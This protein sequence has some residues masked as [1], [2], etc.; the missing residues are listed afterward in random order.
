MSERLSH[1]LLVFLSVFLWFFCGKERPKAQ[2]L[3]DQHV[4]FIWQRN[5]LHTEGHWSKT[6]GFY[7]PKWPWQHIKMWSLAASGS[8]DNIWIF[9]HFIP[10][11]EVLDWGILLQERMCEVYPFLP[12]LAQVNWG[13]ITFMSFQI[14]QNFITLRS[15]M[16]YGLL[17]KYPPWN[18][19]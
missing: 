17:S 13:L 1:I 5:E 3:L 6:Y 18:Q 15:I 19:L 2:S 9:S 16:Q 10:V 8:L 7:T 14:V 4:D 12:G 11:T